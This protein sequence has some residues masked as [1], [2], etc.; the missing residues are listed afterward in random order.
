[1][2]NI[3]ENWK[4]CFQ[5]REKLRKGFKISF[6]EFP[7]LRTPLGEKLI[8]MDFEMMYPGKVE[9]FPDQFNA[10]KLKIK[11]KFDR[12]I[13]QRRGGKKSYSWKD[14]MMKMYKIACI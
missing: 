10:F 12:D 7:S 3:I 9:E 11:Q 14:V 2:Q 5:I 13:T 8:L 4:G 6:G 1:M